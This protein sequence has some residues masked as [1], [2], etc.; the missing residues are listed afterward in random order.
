MLSAFTGL[1]PATGGC[2]WFQVGLSHGAHASNVR[3]QAAVIGAGW[4]RRRGDTACRRC[5]FGCCSMDKR[6]TLRPCVGHTPAL[7]TPQELDALV[8]HIIALKCT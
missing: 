1:I 4:Q 7:F 5:G 6:G 2:S 3:L 8:K